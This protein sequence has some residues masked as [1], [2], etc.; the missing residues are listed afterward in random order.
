M[1]SLL[2]RA[3]ISHNWDRFSHVNTTCRAGLVSRDESIVQDWDKMQDCMFANVCNKMT[4]GESTKKKV[5]R[6]SSEMIENLI[7]CLTTYKA[8]LEY[9]A[10]DFDGDRPAQ[11]K[12]LKKEMAKLYEI[13]DVSL[14][15]PLSLSAPIT[16]IDDMTEEEK[17]EF[18]KNQ[19]KRKFPNSKRPS[20][21]TRKGERKHMGF[22]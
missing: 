18:L 17:K 13:E 19:K 1:G 22:S 10:V 2:Q 12:E 3:G 15:G 20:K 11:Y 6:W 4:E 5:F 8:R 14:F 9:Q 7:T 16:S 21:D